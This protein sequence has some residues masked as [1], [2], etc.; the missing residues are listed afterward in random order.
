MKQY[1]RHYILF[2]ILSSTLLSCKTVLKSGYEYHKEKLSVDLRKQN[3]S[4]RFDHDLIFSGSATNQLD[5]FDKIFLPK[6]ESQ[7]KE[8]GLAV[9]SK[10]EM[11]SL[12]LED[13]L[14]DFTYL[15]ANPVIQGRDTLWVYPIQA[16]L[17]CTE[18]S[19]S[20]RVFFAN[21][22][23]TPEL[24]IRPL[25]NPVLVSENYAWVETGNSI[26]RQ[27]PLDSNQVY[28]LAR[29]LAVRG[30]INADSASALFFKISHP[31]KAA[32]IYAVKEPTEFADALGKVLV[33]S[34]IIFLAVFL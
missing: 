25:Q 10:G 18:T 5:W 19:D 13:C 12:K 8:Q 22:V 7:L 29:N 6:L 32:T 27:K 21:S 3:L 16:S 28:M 31:K 2:L 9:K 11:Q 24:E 4:Y 34:L 33:I 20:M 1:S 23:I 30:A 26:Y 15:P 17:L 14:V